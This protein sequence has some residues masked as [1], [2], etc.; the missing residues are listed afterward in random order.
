MKKFSIKGATWDSVFLAG[1]KILTLLFSILSAKILSTGLSLTEY[2]TYSQAN[3]VNSV[4]TSAILLGLGDA[5]NFFYNKINEDNDENARKRTINTVFFI[6]IVIGAV[7]FAA[8]VL[9]SNLI[10]DYFS[11][12]AIKTLLPIVAVLPV[13]TNLIY[14]FHVLCV[15]VGQA[16]KMSSLNII[17]TI[18]KIFFIYVAV[19]VVHNLVWIYVVLALLELM[20]LLVFYHMMAKKGVYINPFSISFKK[21]KPILAY[22]LPMGVYAVTSAFTREI[23]KLVV[24]RMADTEG[25]AIYTNCSK[26]LP[27]DFTEIFG[28]ELK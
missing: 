25:L 22:S 18:I 13:L 21:I 23:S 19:Y 5:L 26:I 27:F 9:G 11:N 14:F 7:Y 2:G 6:E 12:T 16:K 20:Q 24:G 10:A 28:F 4:G 8:V 1:T 15:S 17:T 3:I